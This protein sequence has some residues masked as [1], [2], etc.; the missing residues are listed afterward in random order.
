MIT[1]V[2]FTNPV[3]DVTENE[4]FFTFHSIKEAASGYPNQLITILCVYY[5]P[6]INGSGFYW[7]HG[8][9]MLLM[10]LRKQA[11]KIHQCVLK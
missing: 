3:D 6:H 1:T 2:Q 4:K 5:K 9:I 7:D 10:S 11:G 8:I